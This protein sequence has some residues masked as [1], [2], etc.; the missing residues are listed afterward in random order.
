MS[1][2]AGT[3]TTVANNATI[4]G[5][6]TQWANSLYN[7][8]KGQ[9]IV[10]TQGTNTDIYTIEEVKSNTSILLSRPAVRSATNATYEILTTLNNSVSDDTIKLGNEIVA[11]SD[12]M[13]IMQAWTT[14]TGDT[15]TVTW[16]SQ[17]I[18]IATVAGL[19]KQIDGKISSTRTWISDKANVHTVLMNSL[20]GTFASG[21]DVVNGFESGG[22]YIWFN[23]TGRTPAADGVVL[24]LPVNNSSYGGCLK[25]KTLVNGAW[26]G[27]YTMIT[28]TAVDQAIKG[29]LTRNSQD[30]NTYSETRLTTSLPASEQTRLRK[31]RYGSNSTI[32]HE[33]VSRAGMQ[34]FSGSEP[35]NLLYTLQ[36]NGNL[37]ISGKMSAD[38]GFTTPNS[39][40]AFAAIL[41]GPESRR[42]VLVCDD[43]KSNYISFHNQGTSNNSSRTAYIGYPIANSS[44]FEIKNDKVGSTLSLD[45]NGARL[46]G[47][48]NAGYLM[49][50]G[51][52]G[53]G[54]TKDI[55]LTQALPTE[56]DILE[57]LKNRNTPSQLWRHS[58]NTGVSTA[59][60][61]NSYS[62]VGDCWWNISVSYTGAQ[63]TVYAGNNSQVHSATIYTN[64]NTT[65]DSN[66]NLK[67]ASPIVK[68]FADHIETN[69]EAEGVTMQKLGVGHYLIKG[70]VGFNADGAWGIN[71]GFVIPQDHNGKNMV[72]I[73]YK[74][75][76][77]GDIEVFVF[78]QQNVDMPE[79]FQNKRIKHLDEDG[80]P[81]YYENYEP[82]DVPES[83]WIDMRVE[84]PVNSLYNKRMK[85]IERARFYT[86]LV[87]YQQEI[88][89]NNTKQLN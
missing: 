25:V 11:M 78:H 85:A 69:D 12:F 70:V 34:W 63:M 17:E 21:T 46:L 60:S 4:T 27:V 77:D 49:T 33:L 74:V 10:I 32:F 30:P 5:A 82:C 65:K 2:K 86:E 72:L 58:Q 51:Q 22:E 18:T 48:S 68:V 83:R 80:N 45:G 44:S 23:H 37:L 67:A 14:G 24:F 1:Y 38:L 66:G 40:E 62:R 15:I 42:L 47:V 29:T 3:V 56:S 36:N 19:Q 79:R 28:D 35:T 54:G 52:F 16:G 7:V 8:V 6:N 55:N 50:V 20:S 64:R 9:I 57:F 13:R 43:D 84:M 39:L 76:P 41:K 87:Q 89:K 53:Y 75:R 73:D 88:V 71:N 26:S 31:M 81:V 61:V 59:Y